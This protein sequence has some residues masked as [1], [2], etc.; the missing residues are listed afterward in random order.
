MK[1]TR[2]ALLI[3]LCPVTLWAE[4]VYL[5]CQ[6]KDAKSTNPFSVMLDEASGKVTHTAHNGSVFNAVGFF[7]ANSIA[8]Q[9][10]AISK[11]IKLTLRY[12]IDR[13]NLTAKQIVIIEAANPKYAI[14]KDITT[15]DG[16]C[17]VVKVAGRKI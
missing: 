12:E 10:I 17:S 5:Q 16:S 4:P 6:V 14:P 9:E 3:A 1:S 7:A 11:G 13:M 2:L 15:M 8:Y